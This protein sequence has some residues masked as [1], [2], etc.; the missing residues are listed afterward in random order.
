MHIAIDTG[1]N[2]IG[3]KSKEEFEKVLKLCSTDIFQID[4]VF[5]HFATADG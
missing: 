3:L 2:R 5:T 1:M 4:G